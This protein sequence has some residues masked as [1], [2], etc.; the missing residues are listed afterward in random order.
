M[1]TTNIKDEVD[2][3]IGGKSACSGIHAAFMCLSAGT[4]P[5]L[6]VITF[7]YLICFEPSSRTR[8]EFSDI[9]NIHEQIGTNMLIRPYIIPSNLQNTKQNGKKMHRIHQKLLF[10]EHNGLLFLL[11]SMYIVYTR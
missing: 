3:S 7:V 9:V 6:G 2:I 10:K 4:V 11:C 5:F 1:Y 8:Q